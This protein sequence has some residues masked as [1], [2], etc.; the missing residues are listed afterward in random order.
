[1]EN[2]V[3]TIYKT[4]CANDLEDFN[5]LLN[6]YASDG[7]IVAYTHSHTIL[8]RSG[9]MLLEKYSV[10]MHKTNAINKATK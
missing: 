1:M 4:I 10:I 2:T 6:R 5:I 8:E 3:T 9:F 7:Y